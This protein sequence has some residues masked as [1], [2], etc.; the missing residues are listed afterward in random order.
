MKRYSLVLS[1]AVCA[2]LATS[3]HAQ[4]ASA[5]AQRLQSLQDNVNKQQH[6]IDDLKAEIERLRKQQA[7]QANATSGAVVNDVAALKEAQQAAKLTAQEQ[8]KTGFNGN[9]FAVTSADGRSSLAVRAVVQADAAHYSQDDAGP[10]A[11]DFRRGSVGGT[12]NRENN[13]ARD[14][15]DGVYFRRARFGVEG[16]IARDFNYRLILELGGAGTEGPTRIND[17]WINY[18]GFA[19]F[20]IQIGAFSPPANLDDGITPDDSLFIERATPAELSRTLGGADGRTALAIRGNGSRWFGSLAYTG[21]TVNDAE[22][23]DAQTALVGRAAFL[24]MTG[25]DFNLHI[26]ASGTYVLHPADQGVDATGVRYGIRFRD[27]PELRVDSTRLIDTNTI[28]ADHAY[29]VG[30][31]LAGNWRGLYLQA[32]NFW[33]GIER[34]A[35]SALGNPNFG[36]YYVQTSWILT[37][38]SHRYN[39][40]TGSYQSPRPF[41]PFSKSG[42][43]GAWEIALRYSDTDLNYQQ[44]TVGFAPFN[45]SVRGGEQ[46]IWT[47]GVNWY[48]N[49]NLRFLLNYLRVDVDRLNPAGPGSLTPFGASPATPPI[50]VA[51]GQSYD[52]FALRSQFNF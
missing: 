19:P 20:T 8:P 35:T 34:G 7:E 45:N 39:M 28:D 2:V 1:A 42:G 37:G 43:L 12:A 44:G 13:G 10:L 52:A 14:L 23:N 40:A 36:G 33:Y 48:V 18:T 24:A 29:A 31:E 26:G 46:K 16:S 6:E 9:R 3:A 4:D 41:L 47:L 17:A 51:I 49:T 5:L 22:V 25:S 38:E 32:E 15:S 30:A 21:R 11:T 27:R 50:G